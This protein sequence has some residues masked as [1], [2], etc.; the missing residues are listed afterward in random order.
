MER[1]SVI[2]TTHFRDSMLR[3]CLESLAAQTAPLHEVVV[4]DDGGSGSAREVVAQFGPQ[5]RYLR[6]PNAGMQN[7]RN[8]GARASSGEWIAFLDD[9]DLWLPER[10][11]RVAEL[12]A[13]GQVDLISGDFTKFGDGWLAPNGVFDEIA[14]RSPGFW[15]GIPRQ[16]GA[17]HSVIGS[18]PTTRLLPVSPFWPSTLVI[19]R[20]LLSRLNGWNEG[21]KGI[22]AEDIEFAFRAIKLGKLGLIWP[23]TVHYRSHVGNDSGSGLAVALGRTQVW[24]LLLLDQELTAA[25]RSALHNAI[26][27]SLHEILYSA[28]SQKEYAT[29]L[30]VSARIDSHNLTIPEKTKIL[31]ARAICGISR[32]QR[33]DIA[34]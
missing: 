30:Q 32:K 1:I 22:K 12:I 8:H 21:L 28:F 17:T 10:H 19:R 18:F 6:Q 20:D 16:P 27:N 31:V 9:D 11:A 23:S 25:E 33:P 14:Q 3:E 5:F 2:V 26:S 7:A 24:E 29:V 13:T 34:P 4:V 15:E